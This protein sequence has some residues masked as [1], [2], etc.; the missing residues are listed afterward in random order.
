[1]DLRAAI[2]QSSQ[3]APH[4]LDSD[5]TRSTLSSSVHPSPGER[6]GQCYPETRCS[7]SSETML[8]GSPGCVDHARAAGAVLR[9][10]GHHLGRCRSWPC[11]TSTWLLAIS[12]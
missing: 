2:V 11:K 6:L 8:W 12:A 7:P 4:R 10:G 1:M 3:A 5:S 9:R